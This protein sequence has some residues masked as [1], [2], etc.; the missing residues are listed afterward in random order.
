MEGMRLGGMRF[1]ACLLALLAASCNDDDAHGK[2]DLAAPDLAAATDAATG[3]LTIPLTA[4]GTGTMISGQSYN[5]ENR[6]VDVSPVARS[7]AVR[8]ITV[9]GLTQTGATGTFFLYDANKKLLTSATA[10]IAAGGTAS[11]TLSTPQQLAVGQTYR[12]SFLQPSSSTGSDG[13][14][15]VPTKVP[16]LEATSLLD[17]GPCWGGIGAAYPT[18]ASTYEPLLVLTVD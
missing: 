16:Y 4:G 11:A 9:G 5:G 6:G 15:F 1:A 14:F 3:P 10:T 12:V 2:P 13:T 7:L 17:V 8:T 18:S